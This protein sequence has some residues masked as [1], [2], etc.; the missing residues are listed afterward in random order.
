MKTYCFEY[1]RYNLFMATNYNPAKVGEEE[2]EEFVLQEQNIHLLRELEF[3]KL[4]A[5]D[6]IEARRE[7]KNFDEF[8][9]RVQKLDGTDK[10]KVFDYESD[11]NDLQIQ[12]NQADQE[13]DQLQTVLNKAEEKQKAHADQLKTLTDQLADI[14][15][16]IEIMQQELEKLRTETSA[17]TAQQDKYQLTLKQQ[18]NLLILENDKMKEIQERINVLTNQKQLFEKEH[19]KLIQIL[20]ENQKGLLSLEKQ[21]E[22]L[23]T[24]LAQLQ[25]EEK[26]LQTEFEQ[27]KIQVDQLNKQLKDTQNNLAECIQNLQQQTHRMHRLEQQQKQ[28]DIEIQILENSMKTIEE[29]LRQVLRFRNIFISI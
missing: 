18:E 24:Q 16:Q 29:S 6:E 4:N 19:Q 25:N 14:T 15:N 7:V 17:L 27:L 10:Q 5:E 13:L 2:E 1:F 28:I 3:S 20:K 21:I 23:N 22:N 11:I 8:E 26:T 12:I 9:S